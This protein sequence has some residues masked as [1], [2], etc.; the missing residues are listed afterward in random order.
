MFTSTTQ[1]TRPLSPQH[2]C[3]SAQGAFDGTTP[4]QMRDALLAYGKVCRK[5]SLAL[6]FHGGLV[7]R[8]T[9]LAAAAQLLGPLA[10]SATNPDDTG[11][12]A[13]PYFLVWDSGLWDTLRQNLP[14]IGSE[15]IFQRLRDIIGSAAQGV[16]GDAPPPSAQLMR[17]RVP[18]LAVTIPATPSTELSAN[19]VDA[20]QRAVDADPFINAEKRRIGAHAGVF[21]T[22]RCEEQATGVARQVVTSP[23]T[24]LSPDV[25]N[26]ILAEETARQVQVSTAP[27]SVPQP[28][29]GILA[30]LAGRVLT[31]IIQRYASGRNHN[32]HNTVVEEIF[33]HYYIA[34]VGWAIWDAMKRTAADSFQPD[35]SKFVG[36]AI[37]GQLIDLYES[38]PDGKSAR[39][40]LIGHSAGAT[41]ICNFLSAMERAL[42]AKSYAGNI[43]FD[44]IFL[45]PSVRVDLLA[46]N[47]GDHRALI[48][49]F[50]TFEMSDAIE[51][52]E[53]LLQDPAATDDVNALLAQVY[54]SSLLYFIAGVL[55]DPDDDTPLSGM[56]RYFLGQG[57]FGPGTFPDI[58]AVAAFYRSRPAAVIV[59]DTAAVDPPPPLGQRCGSH[60]HGSFPFD[61]ATLQSV[62]YLLRTG[63]F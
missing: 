62:C 43:K 8:P 22:Q 35:P 21:S 63:K 61:P 40:V 51:A 50:R 2:Y 25:V 13:Y 19:D 36:S 7:D 1:T 15:V 20:V 3:A 9:G 41:Y 52:A 59:S 54:T 11:G 24:L 37:I 26:G 60:H 30:L 16:L 14:A 32:F 47:L 48:R 10:A 27:K 5:Q 4:A 29:M 23:L 28:A 49:D 31:R 12:N 18:T 57:A 17:R 42:Q 34:N 33:R 53:P 39:V 44:V 56:Q 46:S 38:N 45:A 58:D 6:F 55:E